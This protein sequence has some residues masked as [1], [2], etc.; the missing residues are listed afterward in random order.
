MPAL[1]TM[2]E[3]RELVKCIFITLHLFIY[4]VYI[5]QASV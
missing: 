2:L 5:D 3:E 1:D 4:I